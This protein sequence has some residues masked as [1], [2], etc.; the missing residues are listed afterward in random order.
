[1][2]RGEGPGGFFRVLLM[3]KLSARDYGRSVLYEEVPGGARNGMR[4]IGN[5]I[6]T[7]AELGWFEGF[8][9]FCRRHSDVNMRVYRYI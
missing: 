8:V 2:Y 6:L 4:F 3:V 9:V 7:L 1:M 5:G